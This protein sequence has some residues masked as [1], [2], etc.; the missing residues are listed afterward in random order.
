[1]PISERDYMRQRVDGASSDEEANQSAAP[2]PFA[3]CNL[4][5][6]GSAPKRDILEAAPT[7]KSST[8]S[9]QSKGA[10]SYV[11]AVIS[12]GIALILGI[13]IG[14]SFLKW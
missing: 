2:N 14:L 6:L 4:Q 10:A 5:S 9:S 3:G 8:S 7:Q 1:M 11:I 13:L 12:A